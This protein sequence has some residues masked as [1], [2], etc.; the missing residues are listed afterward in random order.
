MTSWW[1]YIFIKCQVDEMT[2]WWNDKLIKW[3]A[4]VMARWQNDQSS[5][6]NDQSPIFCW[7]KKNEQK[8]LFD[9]TNDDK[10]ASWPNDV[11]PFLVNKSVN[12]VETRK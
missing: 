7:D 4:N 9:K 12:L 3:K 11:A 2:N 8:G 1:N 6:W 5:W 10:S